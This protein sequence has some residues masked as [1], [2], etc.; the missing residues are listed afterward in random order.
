MQRNGIRNGT[1]MWIVSYLSDRTEKVHVNGYTS[2][3]VPLKY[4]VPQGSVLGLLLF[5]MYTGELEHII[6]SDV[7]LSY[8][9]ADHCQHSF[10]CN[11]GETESLATRG[12][13]VLMM[14][15]NWMSCN[16]LKVNPTKTEF[17]WAATS[18]LQHFIPR[19]PTTLSGVDIIPSRCAKLLGVYIDLCKALLTA[20]R[21]SSSLR[22]LLYFCSLT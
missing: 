13:T 20:G 11:P 10:F 6:N 17:L 9:Y 3:Y 15:F 21:A 5:I 19:G 12:S 8:C 7:L 14:W 18:R 4:G 16:R 22:Q 1:L 2:L